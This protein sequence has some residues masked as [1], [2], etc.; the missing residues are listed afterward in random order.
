MQAQ[1]DHLKTQ[2][3]EIFT[4]PPNEVPGKYCFRSCLFK[5]HWIPWYIGSHQKPPD[6]GTSG[7][8]GVQGDYYSWCIG[9]HCT[10]T[11]LVMTSGGQ[12]MFKLV[13]LRLSPPPKPYCPSVDNLKHYGCHRGYTSWHN[14][15]DWWYFLTAIF[16]SA[17]SSKESL[18]YN[19]K[20]WLIKAKAEGDLKFAVNKYHHCI[21]SNF[22]TLKLNHVNH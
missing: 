21:I 5:L 11:P 8:G 17:S 4:P 19:G 20:N 6:V 10:G 18:D 3:E 15:K 22:S 12:Y 7:G 13:H 14:L 1:C 2:Q 16:C 9:A